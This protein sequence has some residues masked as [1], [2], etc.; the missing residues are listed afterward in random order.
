MGQGSPP[1]AWEVLISVFSLA[2]QVKLGN[3][4]PNT[5]YL[6]LMHFALTCID[7]FIL[8]SYSVKS[9][10]Q[11]QEFDIIDLC[12]SSSDEESPAIQSLSLTSDDIQHVKS[13]QTD[14]SSS[15]DE[16]VEYY[17]GNVALPIFKTGFKGNSLTAL[18]ITQQLL[19]TDK[20]EVICHTVPTNIQD[21]VVFLVNSA[22]FD[23]V[24]DLKCD[25]LGV[26]RANKVQSNFFH[27]YG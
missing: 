25:D 27:V 9:L 20:S 22:S 17:G 19:W 15:S 1:L 16:E 14:S 3:Y 7:S 26:W 4:Y 11:T 23:N 13:T 10:S 21:D 18:D 5:S 2:R 12:C 8:L 24:D 6:L